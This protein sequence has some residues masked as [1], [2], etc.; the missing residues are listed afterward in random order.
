MGHSL[1]VI[2]HANILPGPILLAVSGCLTK[3]NSSALVRLIDKGADLQGCPEFRV[4]LDDLDHMELSGLR[5]IEDYIRQR[6][7]TGSLPVLSLQ[8]P[9][10][11]R[12]CFDQIPSRRFRTLT[13][14]GARQPAQLSEEAPTPLLGVAA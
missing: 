12:H 6:N 5:V 9:A 7:T 3:S 10:S 13:G 4:D 8:A 2:V 1:G 11:A 14:R